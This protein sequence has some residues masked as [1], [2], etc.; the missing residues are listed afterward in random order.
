MERSL[1]CTVMNC[2]S[3]EP[4]ARYF[5]PF[6]LFNVYKNFLFP[7]KSTRMEDDKEEEKMNRTYVTTGK[8]KQQWKK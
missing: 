6:N 7:G 8:K 4:E 5:P 2:R 3:R 1:A